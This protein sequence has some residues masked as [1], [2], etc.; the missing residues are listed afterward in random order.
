[1]FTIENLF[2]AI[3]YLGGGVI[4]SSVTLFLT[5]AILMFVWRTFVR[6]I[7]SLGFVTPNSVSITPLP[8]HDSRRY[9]SSSP[10]R[11]D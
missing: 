4:V 11:G 9:M 10:S 2:E 5:L 7:H 1:M 3:V 6:L 8:I